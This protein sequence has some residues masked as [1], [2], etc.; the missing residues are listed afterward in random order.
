MV[1]I[2]EPDY[3]DNILLI[4]NILSFG[5]TERSIFKSINLYNNNERTF[6]RKGEDSGKFGLGYNINFIRK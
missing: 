4:N 5:D 1:I 3:L 2:S 6:I